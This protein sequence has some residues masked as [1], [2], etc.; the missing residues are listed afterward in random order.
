MDSRALLGRA[1]KAATFSQQHKQTALAQP[2]LFVIEYALA[3]L[4]IQWGIRPQAMLGYSLGEYV[5]ACVA[6]V[7]SLED[8][9][10]LVARRAQ[11][12]ENLPQGTM[13]TVMLSEE[14]IQPYLTE[15]VCLAAINGPTTC[16]LA[17]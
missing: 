16:V 14:A 6:G 8:A 12:I 4:L 17:G 9:L 5:A 15:H 3:R 2:A 1:S 13:L 7:L 11:L 10:L